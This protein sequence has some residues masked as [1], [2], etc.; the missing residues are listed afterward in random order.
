MDFDQ[1]LTNT[2]IMN[3]FA[4]ETENFHHIDSESENSK[5]E[6]QNEQSIVLNSE[7]VKF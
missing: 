4:N 2:R 3:V 1:T 5:G 7:N 6:C